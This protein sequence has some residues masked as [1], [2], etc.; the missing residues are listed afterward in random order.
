[1]VYER[2]V[3]SGTVLW[4][5]KTS[6]GNGVGSTEIPLSGIDTNNEL[7]GLV[8]FYNDMKLGKKQISLTSIQLKNGFSV[9][10][11]NRTVFNV[12]KPIASNVLSVIVMYGSNYIYKIT[13]L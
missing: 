3:K 4:E 11:G 12:I 1:M 6:I 9:E 13:A 2:Y 7:K 8:I 10:E 5:G